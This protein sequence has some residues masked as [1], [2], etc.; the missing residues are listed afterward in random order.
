MSKPNVF[1][2][3]FLVMIIF[4]MTS[5]A[6]DD[7]TINTTQSIRDR[8]G[9][10]LVSSGGKFEMGFFS[11]GNSRNRYVGIWFKN[12]TVLTYVWVANR[13]FPLT[14]TSGVLRVIHPGI[15]FLING[16]NGTIVWS[17]SNTSM[18]LQ[19]PVAQLLD[20]GNLVVRDRNNDRPEN[21]IWQS[22]DHPT[23]TYLPGMNLGWNLVTEKEIYLSSWKSNDDPGTGE[24]SFGLDPTGYPQMLV[25]RGQSI[26]SRIG[27]WNGILF[28]G[29]PR[30]LEE[31]TYTHTFM[32]DEEKVYYRSDP[33]DESFISRYTINHTGVS[34]KLT[35]VDRTQGWVFYF[36]LPADICDTYKLC[37]VYGSCNFGKSPSCE[38]LD[39]FVPKDLDGWNRLDWSSGCI[40]RTNLSCQGD[41]FLKYSGIKLP[42][43]RNSWHNASMTLEEC[44]EEC[45]RN[46]S[47]MAYKQLDIRRGTGCL[48]WYDE[49]VDIRTLT[50]DGQQIYIRIASSESDFRGKKREILMASLATVLGIV[51]T[52]LTLFLYIRRRKT[53]L[54]MRKEGKYNSRNHGKDLDLPFFDLSVIQKA[55]NDLS[56]KNK[57]GEGGFGPVYKFS[58]GSF[59]T[60]YLYL[61]AWTLY[62]E[63]RSREL[64]DTCVDKEFYSWEVLRSIQVGLLCVQQKPE[65]R[66]NM[67]SVVVMLGNEGEIPTAK[68]PGFFTQRDVN[69]KPANSA[70]EVT[71]TVPEPR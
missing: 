10:T 16:T 43:A 42:D 13:D 35:W 67:S 70:N 31:N 64:V 36:N 60:N 7:D 61:Q 23:D 14:D 57:L 3:W 34:Q 68:Q 46:C 54:K 41:G 59:S 66:P 12:I 71:I 55:T 2:T 63:G 20:S 45:L 28:P 56:D 33:I 11:P 24:Y 37:G 4:Q 17:S 49:L 65:D 62:K 38:C 50:R 30:P 22:F 29:P 48:I 6:I 25:K 40:R 32:M 15:L 44:R 21:F 27:P 51:L 18:P 5:A 9:E 19:N 58:L 39:R 8:D 52:C 1:P 26:V 47:C 53:N 69:T